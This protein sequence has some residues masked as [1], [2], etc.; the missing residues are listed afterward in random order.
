[1]SLQGCSLSELR[2]SQ[3]EILGL[4]YV[5]TV[6]I[7][8]LKSGSLWAYHN[9]VLPFASSF[10]CVIQHLNVFCVEHFNSSPLLLT[11]LMSSLYN[12]STLQLVSNLLTFIFG[13]RKCSFC[14]GLNT[15]K[16]ESWLFNSILTYHLYCPLLWGPTLIFRNTFHSS[17]FHV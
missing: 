2:V 11:M 1:M 16:L 3:V 5:P 12:I 17:R 7:C 10:A 9:T 6:S 4:T 14:S 8:S 15:S 13:C